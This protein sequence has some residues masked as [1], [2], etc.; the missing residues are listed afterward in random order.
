M[1]NYSSKSDKYQVKSTEYYKKTIDKLFKTI[2][3]KNSVIQYY[4]NQSFINDCEIAKLRKK[5]VIQE[6]DLKF[7]LD[8]LAALRAEYDHQTYIK[9]IL[10]DENNNDENEFVD[11]C[12]SDDQ[13]VKKLNLSTHVEKAIYA[14]L[15]KTFKN[16]ILKNSMR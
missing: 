3:N 6:L 4:M 15:F 8:R 11:L 5:I 12:F 13:T 14:S 2:D 7:T 9:K 16:Q 10:L 1:G